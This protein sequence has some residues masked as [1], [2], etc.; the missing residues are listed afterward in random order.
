MGIKFL[1]EPVD[2]YYSESHPAQD[3]LDSSND[4]HDKQHLRRDDYLRKTAAETLPEVPAYILM[5][6]D[7]AAPGYLLCTFCFMDFKG[8][9]VFRFSIDMKGLCSS[10]LYYFIGGMES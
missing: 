9:S 1:Y 10:Y 2:E 3:L 6:D 4:Q 8:A 5:K 7:I